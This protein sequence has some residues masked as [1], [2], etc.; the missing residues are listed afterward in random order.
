MTT[1]RIARIASR[2]QQA[3]IVCRTVLAPA[4]IAAVVAFTTQAS[5]QVDVS[6]PLPNVLLLVDTSGSMEY[7]IDGSQVTCAKVDS[8]LSNEPQGTSGKSRWTQLVE[9]LTG[10]IVGYSCRTQDRRSAAFRTEYM[11]GTA[12]A[13]DYMYSVPYHRILYT[14]TPA[15]PCTIGPGVAD[16]NPFAWGATPFAY[17]VW[18]DATTT[19]APPQQAATGI[20]DTYADRVRFGLMTFDTQ[21]SPGTGVGTGTTADYAT[22][23]AGTWS[24]F[25]N[26]MSDPSCPTDQTGN[27]N[28]ALG[29]PAGCLALSQMEV[30]ARNAA[31]PPWEGRMVPFGSPA[32]SITEVRQNST[33]IQQTLL[34]TRPFGATPINGMLADAS[35]FLTQ[36]AS[37]DPT[38]AGSTSCSTQDPEVCFGPKSDPF[39][40]GGCR[41]NFVI[42]LTDG[43]PNLDLRPYCEATGGKCPY[44]D[45]PEAIV[46]KLAELPG[47]PILTFVIGFAVSTVDLGGGQAPVDCASLGTHLA[48]YCGASMNPKLAAC[49]TLAKLAY[50]G[51]TS[52]A[53]FVTN[54]TDLRSALSDILS[55]VSSVATSRTVPV[56]GSAAATSTG[57]SYTFYSSFVVASG[58]MWQGKL[59][60]QRTTCVTERQADG[61]TRTY[62]AKQDVTQS[63][64]DDFAY[65][66]NHASADSSTR[67]RHYYTVLATADSSGK[68]WSDRSIRPSLP[69]TNL[70]GAGQQSGTAVDGYDSDFPGKVSGASMQLTASACSDSAITTADQCANRIMKWEIGVTNGSLPNRAGNVFGDIYHA[71]PVLV[72]PPNET[73]RDESYTAFMSAYSRRPVVLYAATNDGQLHAFKVAATDPNDTFKVDQSPA[74]NELWSFFPPAV[75]PKLIAQYPTSHQML[76]DSTPIVKDVVFARSSQAAKSGGAVGDWHTV[77][78]EG[79]GGGGGGYF[80]VDITKPVPV[81]NDATTGP[82]FLWQ[83]TSDASGLPL[84]GSSSAVPAITTLYFKAPGRSEAMEYA[85]AILPGGGGGVP[86]GA[87]CAQRATAELVDS[88]F[89]PRDK[90]QCW[91]SGAARSVSV[92]MLETGEILRTFRAAADGPASTIGRAGDPTRYAVLDA[93]MIGQPVAY[94]GQAGSVANRAFIGDADGMLWR[95]DLASTNPNDWAA[96]LWFD[97]YN[98]TVLPTTNALVPGQRI[99][100]VPVVSSDAIGNV[101]VA[102]STGDQESFQYSSGMRTFL[103]S[104]KEDAASTPSSFKSQVLWYSQ[105]NDG[106]RVSGPMQIYS[107]TLYYTVMTPTLATDRA[108]ACHAGGSDLCGVDYMEAKGSRTSGNGG[109]AALP[110]PEGST[111]TTRQQCRSLG[112]VVTF[113]AAIAQTPT[114]TVQET[115]NDPYLGLPNHLSLA[116]GIS[117]GGSSLVVNAAS[118]TRS[119]SPTT[120]QLPAPRRT[121]RI[122]SWASLIE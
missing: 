21:T 91:A 99:D 13:P 118:A 40:L 57:G 55:R 67:A 17:H 94:P 115:Y 20:L 89:G 75:L 51:G 104:L 108:N 4:G 65:N 53:H 102:F 26:W 27:A 16:T 101:T 103:Y 119:A 9:V 111:D 110:P 85:V 59:T 78:V 73:L 84:F 86:T 18:N 107:G 88:A 122:D 3:P 52:N 35:A 96:N 80:A 113:G 42:L 54:A 79:F 90:V 121:T 56:Y 31:A 50:N 63:A 105:Y 43:E 11:L 114:C 74:Q 72:G 7:A 83:L 39:V 117:G 34:A 24:Y 25:L 2:R 1:H 60:R 68:V 30:G 19:C 82:K 5:A 8:T 98:T 70:D 76:L 92:V 37:R 116:G 120:I 47:N 41:K 58:A 15:E 100:T 38:A 46:K 106:A 112:Q 48:D 49:C 64:A 10:D 28:C 33:R 12:D 77:L 95:L 14:S 23:T 36:D 66:V 87:T 69:A 22:G 62:P 45:K 109:A 29:K 61:T 6:P 97:A 32:A 71:T 93:P 44:D 81:T